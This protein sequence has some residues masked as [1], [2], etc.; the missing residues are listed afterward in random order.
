MGT[1]FWEVVCDERGIGGSSDYCGKNDAHLGHISG[2]FHE[3]F[4]GKYNAD[5]LVNN[6]RGK[7]NW[8]KDHYKKV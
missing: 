6:L 4:N 5:N 2:F 3:A 7:K 8:A 1:K